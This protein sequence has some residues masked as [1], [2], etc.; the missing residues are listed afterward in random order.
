L[1]GQSESSVNG[2]L[3]DTG[4]AYEDPTVLRP[5]ILLHSCCGPCSTSVV[6][7]LA[8]RFRITIYFCNSNI[9]DEA[10][11]LRRLEAQKEYILRYNA[12]VYMSDPISLVIAP[13]TPAAFLKLTEGYENCEEGGER[14]RLCIGD[15]LDRAAAY[16]AI[17][18]YEFFSTTLS[19]SRHK[20][21]DMILEF[22]KA[23]ALKYGLSFV[24]DDFKRGGG[25]QRADLL[26][27]SYGLYRQNFCGCSFSKK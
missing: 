15:R 10:E 2:A 17:N 19:V 7:K 18:G 8:P 12:S 25:D 1:I 23:L 22:G 20:S 14:C 3:K 11:Y 5:A 13:Y 6:E 26:A 9:D 21:Y 27:K 16:A 24:D 4:I